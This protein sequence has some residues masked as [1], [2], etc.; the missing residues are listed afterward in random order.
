M[1]Q[2]P[3]KKTILV[4]DNEP[5]IISIV[6]DDSAG[7]NRMNGAFLHNFPTDYR[8]RLVAGLT[9][10]LDAHGIEDGEIMISGSPQEFGVTVNGWKYLGRVGFRTFDSDLQHLLDRFSHWLTLKPRETRNRRLELAARDAIEVVMRSVPVS[11]G[12]GE[13]RG[14]IEPHL[15][16]ARGCLRCGP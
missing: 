4:V 16:R 12:R 1:E 5:E 9:E 14:M 11:R 8:E 13:G 15:R 3:R 6:G 7:K 2:T 10:R